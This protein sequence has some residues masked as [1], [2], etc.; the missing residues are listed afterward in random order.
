MEIS[1]KELL[2]LAAMAFGV[3]MDG[4]DSS[5]VNIALPSIAEYF[6]VDAGVAAWVTVVYLMMIAGMMLIFG[7]LA[8]SGRIKRI[9]V[10][11]FALFGISSLFCGISA[12]FPMLVAARAVQ[13]VGA[14]MLAA[15][16][17]MIC[18][19][20]VSEDRLGLA[21]SLFMLA[22]SVGY[23]SG[24]AVGGLIVDIASWHWAFLINVPI[25]VAAILI[26]LRALP[27]DGPVSGSKPDL[28]GCA[29][30]FLAV[31][32]GTYIIE[33]FSHE[34]QQGVCL[35]LAAVM[36]VSILLFIRNERRAERPVI[37]LDM[38]RNWR[39]D[40]VLLCYLLISLVYVGS[41]YLVPFYFRVELLLSYAVGGLLIMI[42]SIVSMALGVPAGR[43]GDRHGR[44]NLCI[45]GTAALTAQSVCLL[46]LD[47]ETGWI[48][49]IPIGVL[50]GVLWGIGGSV[51]SR[52]VDESPRS[53]RSISSTISNFVY[54]AGGCIGTAV[55][56]ALVTV[57]SGAPGIP[58]DQI[59]AGDFMDGFRLAMLFAVLLSAASL[60]CAWAVKDR[61]TA[62]P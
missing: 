54:Y 40:S 18:V 41:S 60:F 24:P 7:R 8:D 13:G 55:F 44:R 53:D 57:G 62:A 59:S 19:K 61:K 43:Y 45:I 34:G 42:P 38:F 14:A 52:I 51:A 20:Y 37:G 12:N 39:F 6:G 1:R 47:P 22:G 9:Y 49:F 26:S 48:P 11:G 5:I 2:A 16:S 31:I 35:A 28:T 33:M 21:M 27:K 25:S 15:V 17:P 32:S 46:L 23:L 30:L 10:I 36:A 50:G 3:F 56:A 58:I 4:L 29:A